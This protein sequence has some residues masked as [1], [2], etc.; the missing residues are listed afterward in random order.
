M[1]ICYQRHN[2]ETPFLEESCGGA[3]VRGTVKRL[4]FCSIHAWKEQK[5]RISWQSFDIGIAFGSGS[6][7]VFIEL[8][9]A[10]ALMLSS[11]TVVH[12]CPHLHLRCKARLLIFHAR[13]YS[14][15]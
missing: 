6:T 5:D 11:A 4:F 14:G 10:S 15:Y 7:C 12:N 3:A 1:L 2:G 13:S 9:A 8:Q